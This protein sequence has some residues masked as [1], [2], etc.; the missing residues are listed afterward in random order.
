MVLGWVYVTRVI[1]YIFT[2]RF[3]HQKVPH[4]RGHISAACLGR[5]I[6]PWTAW[7]VLATF[8]FRKKKPSKFSKNNPQ[9]NDIFSMFRLASS[10]ACRAGRLRLPLSPRRL[11]GA[12]PPFLP[13]SPRGT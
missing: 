3:L 6:N 4:Q 10:L 9:Y 2:I 13:A 12:G 8:I 11:P 7:I 5:R 1:L